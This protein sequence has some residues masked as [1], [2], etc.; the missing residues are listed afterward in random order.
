MAK[1]IESDVKVEGLGQTLKALHERGERAAD[2]RPV[3]NKARS[4]FLKSE[5]RLYEEGLWIPNEQSTLERKSRQG[6]D[7]RTERQTG[8]MEKSLTSRRAKGAVNRAKKQEFKFGTSLWY[9]KFQTGTATQ[10]PRTMIHLSK[11]E[12]KQ[13]DDIIA[14]WVNRGVGKG[15][16]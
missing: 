5:K 2:I 16:W 4:V 11:R 15:E 12:V 13:I 1:R 10:L 6:Y 9:A 8:A 3:K 14:G 7:L